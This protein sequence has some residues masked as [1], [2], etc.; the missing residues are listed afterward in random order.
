METKEFMQQVEE[1]KQ[2]IKDNLKKVT[3]QGRTNA[4]L[5]D[6]AYVAKDKVFEFEHSPFY[7]FVELNGTFSLSF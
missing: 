6:V 5:Y 2:N 4:K 7:E 3:N 1:L